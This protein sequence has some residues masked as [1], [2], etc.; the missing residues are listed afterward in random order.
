VTEWQHEYDAQLARDLA[1]VER[2]ERLRVEQ[3]AMRVNGPAWALTLALIA[4]AA[5]CYA[6]KY[7]GLVT[8]PRW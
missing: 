5:V 2:L 7:F 3:N 1:T 8:T 4:G 6:A